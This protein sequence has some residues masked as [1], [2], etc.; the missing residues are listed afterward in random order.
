MPNDF[1]EK[2]ILAKTA[3]IARRRPYF[4][5]LRSSLGSTTYNRYSIFK[6]AISRPGGINLIAEIKKASPSK[7]MIREDFDP[8]ALAKT[9]QECGAAAFSVLTEEDFFLGKP[10][11]L[12]L[13]SDEYQV[14]SLMK[15][16]FIDELQLF[17]ARWCG[18]S[19]VL[20]IAAILDDI[21]LKAML[22]H[23]HALDLD[24]LVEVHDGVELDRALAMGAE[25]IGINNRNLR[26]FDV[27]LSVAETL[28]PRIPK[29]KVIVAESGITTHEQVNR[30]QALGANA[31][32]IGETFMR[33]KDVARKVR[34]VMG[35]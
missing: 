24:C 8:G 20:L 9:Y 15:D 30:L 19:A 22:Q 25:I 21:K 12:K 16:F 18:A 11:Y 27:S 34:E 13:I 2:I 35:T 33:E 6:Q 31:V 28:I 5:K 17:E 29:G 23:A 1:L 10:A 3:L 32:L 4:E 14:P 7:G 26:T